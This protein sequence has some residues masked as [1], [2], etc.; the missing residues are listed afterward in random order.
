MFHTEDWIRGL[1]MLTSKKKKEKNTTKC[2][3]IMFP[4]CEKNED[5]NFFHG[6]VWTFGQ[7][8]QNI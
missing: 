1:K 7:K 4:A 3:C 2:V 5:L 6:G 8:N